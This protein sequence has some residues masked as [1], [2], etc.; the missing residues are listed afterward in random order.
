MKSIEDKN[1]CTNGPSQEIST[2]GT[3]MSS[4]EF[5]RGAGT[6]NRSS[7]QRISL[8]KPTPSKWDDAQKWLIGL[9]RAG[10]DSKYGDQSK[11]EPRNSNADDLRLINPV[12]Q[13]EQGCSSGEEDEEEE[14][15]E[16]EEYGLQDVVKTKKVEC[17][18]ESI[19]RV[20]KAPSNSHGTAAASSAVRSI[21]LRDTGTEMT[22]I[23]SQ[24][25][26]RTGTPIRAS[27]PVG[28]SPIN[29]GS[30]TPARCNENHH[31]Q[32]PVEAGSGQLAAANNISGSCENGIL[33]QPRKLNTLETRAM[34]WDEAE[35]AKYMARYH[36]QSFI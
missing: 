4:F 26:S 19:W 11:T 20:S 6:T 7:H 12:P 13:R 16:E 17:D 30:S 18:E 1:C 21:C 9:S 10:G 3:A 25:P 14:E 22:P 29:S 15:E 32:V 33:D 34:A 35:R 23:A 28:R 24:E 31:H 2:S 27:T 5:H 8:G 36:H